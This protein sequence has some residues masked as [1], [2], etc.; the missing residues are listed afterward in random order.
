MFSR[1]VRSYRRRLLIAYGDS[2]LW[3]AKTLSERIIAWHQAALHSEGS[4]HCGDANNRWPSPRV[5]TG[6]DR[7]VRTT[8]FK[9]GSDFFFAHDRRTSGAFGMS[10]GLTA[11]TPVSIQ[12]VGEKRPGGL[13]AK[14]PVPSSIQTPIGCSEKRPLIP[15]SMSRS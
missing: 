4:S 8:L 9:I 2:S 7:G 13:S 1:T 15:R 11:A 10:L 12:E 14:C 6:T 5:Q 3:S